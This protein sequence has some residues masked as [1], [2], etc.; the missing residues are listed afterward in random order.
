MIVGLE[1]RGVKKNKKR[2]FQFSTELPVLDFYLSGCG[3]ISTNHKVN[4]RSLLLVRLLKRPIKAEWRARSHGRRI[5]LSCSNWLIV[6]VLRGDW[7]V[8]HV[9]LRAADGGGAAA[10]RAKLPLIRCEGL[11]GLEVADAVFIEKSTDWELICFSVPSGRRGRPG[12]G[13]SQK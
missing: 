7:V 1:Q 4:I 9:R 3:D 13:A 8:H 10:K 2:V 12:D 11:E 5:Y 6:A